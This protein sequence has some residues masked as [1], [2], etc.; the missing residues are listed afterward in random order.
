MF[1][2]IAPGTT[3]KSVVVT[4]LKDDGTANTS[5]VYNSAS[6]AISYQRGANATL[7]AITL[8]TL[9]SVTASY[10]SGGFIHIGSG[11]YRLDLPNA[12][13]ATSATVCEI[14][15]TDATDIRGLPK[16]I[17]LDL[18]APTNWNLQSID[19]SGK[20]YPADASVDPATYT[21]DFAA[22]FIADMTDSTKAE[23]RAAILNVLTYL[24][25]S[26]GS[27]SGSASDI[28]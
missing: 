15:V 22:Q 5:L 12:A 11:R 20:V 13:I 24:N 3:S 19:A 14:I 1:E 9:A 2:R 21:S 17:L 27:G 26:G 16:T 23:V 6:L 28:N 18:S 8:A 7:T 4:I 10:S 25:T